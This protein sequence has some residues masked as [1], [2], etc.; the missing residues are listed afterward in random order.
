MTLALADLERSI[1]HLKSQYNEMPAEFE[2][3]ITKRLLN[4]YNIYIDLL[5]TLISY[6]TGVNK[7]QHI[8]D[9]QTVKDTQEQHQKV[10]QEFQI[11]HN[12]ELQNEMASIR[13]TGYVIEI[14]IS[15]DNVSNQKRIN[16]IK[17]YLINT[18]RNECLESQ[19]QSIQDEFDEKLKKFTDELNM[20]T[21]A[22]IEQCMKST[23]F[24][25]EQL[26]S[27]VTKLDIALIDNNNLKNN[28]IS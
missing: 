12:I 22:I 4:Q 2:I 5:K 8:I 26:I 6:Q 14:F 19:R 16:Q 28:I 15:P 9:D 24:Q 23:K 13:K 21:T 3:N 7:L 20:E 25:E 11:N 27:Y 10:L 17:N 1:E 18:M